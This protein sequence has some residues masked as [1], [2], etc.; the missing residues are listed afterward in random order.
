MTNEYSERVADSRYDDFLRTRRHPDLFVSRTK[1]KNWWMKP[2]SVC[3][4]KWERG[5][6]KLKRVI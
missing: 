2:L 3:L 6:R 4:S 1:I 5:E